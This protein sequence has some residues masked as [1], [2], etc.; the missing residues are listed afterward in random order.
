M[1]NYSKYLPFLALGFL[2]CEPELQNPIDEP[3]YYS[4]GEADFTNYVALGNSLTAGYADNALYITGQENSY[5]N[6]LAQQFSV[7]QETNEFRQPLM[8]DNAGG[9]LAG[10][11]QIT[12]N[13]RILAVGSSGN[14]SPVVYT[15]TATTDITNVLSGPF[16]NL[17][18][19]GAKSYHLLAPGYGDITGV[20]TGTANPYFVRF[21]SSAQTSVLEDAV[22]QNPTFFSL[23]I[24]NND[25]LGYA[26]SGGVGED[27][28]GN[29]DP[30]TY[31]S[32][33]ITDPNV[34]ASVYSEMVT[35]LTGTG[36]EGVLINIPDV[37]TVPFF[38]TVP[39]NALVLDAETAAN[40]T[41]F[42]RAVTGIVAGSAMSQGVPEPQA[43]ALASQYAINFSEGPN[44]FLIDVP[45]SQQNPLG[46]RQMTEEEMLVLTIDQAALAQGYGSVRLNQEVMQVLGILQQGGQPTPEQAQLVLD[47][48]DGIDDEDALDSE[49]IDNIAAA[50]AAYNTTIRNIAQANGLA[51]VDAN[52]LLTQLAN[53]GISFDAG[54]LTST[55]VTG[56]AFSLDGVHPTPRGQAAIANEIIRNINNTYD[57]TVPVVNI[58]NYGTVTL[59]NNV[60]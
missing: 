14:P 22:A 4:S 12:G 52:A 46:F 20:A 28:T 5:P 49:E 18:A 40:L 36:A 34:F 44:R 26:T 50:T 39:N 48:V 23:W 27:Q 24:G 43:M 32:N 7:V 60:E 10:G 53:G 35:A 33:D 6:I 37:T 21:A 29:L 8:A 57:A 41:G 30:T 3:G 55:F 2:A 38:T 15:G 11:N 58:G 31:G 54:T 9:L 56:G 25:V 16:N 45:V 42:F 47:A 59:S 19:P 51:H 13:R 1:K 17:G